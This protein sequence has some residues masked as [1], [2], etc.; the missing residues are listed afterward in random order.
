MSKHIHIIPINKTL[1]DVQN[2]TSQTK[3]IF[4]GKTIIPEEIISKY[5]KS[6][7]KV[8]Y[9]PDLINIDD[10]VR[11]I[12][13]KIFKYLNESSEFKDKFLLEEI[14]INC[15]ENRNIDKELLFEEINS[16][17]NPDEFFKFYFNNLSDEKSLNYFN[18]IKGFS[19]SSLH[20]I[21]SKKYF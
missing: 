16:K 10:S 11:T 6:N 20:K 2:K 9:I 15:K 14:Y 7:D 8:I 21:L 12:K 17:K 4:H 13:Y 1:D 18:S 3:L 5:V 19:Y